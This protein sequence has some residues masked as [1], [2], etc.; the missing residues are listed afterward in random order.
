MIELI[1]LLLC[2]FCKVDNKIID[3]FLNECYFVVVVVFF[4]CNFYVK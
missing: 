4:N 3:Y 1:N 2:F